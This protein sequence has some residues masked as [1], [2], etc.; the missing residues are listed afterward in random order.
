MLVSLLIKINTLMCKPH[1]RC[2]LIWKFQQIAHYLSIL[3]IHVHVHVY[4]CIWQNN[5]DQ[6]L[7]LNHSSFHH[8]VQEVNEIQYQ[9][10]LII[11]LPGYQNFIN[12]LYKMAE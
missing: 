12:F 9:R 11:A 4:T 7:T 2:K 8:F 6:T 10:S 5:F 3:Y 1:L